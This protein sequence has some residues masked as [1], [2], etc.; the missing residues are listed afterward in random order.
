MSFKN[1]DE[2]PQSSR[3]SYVAFCSFFHENTLTSADDSESNGCSVM[4]RLICEMVS[5]RTRQ[6][7]SSSCGAENDVE[8]TKSSSL[9]IP[10]VSEF[11]WRSKQVQE[12]K[13][14]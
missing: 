1:L 11:S 4:F 7:S 5:L 13:I 12:I 10:G 2:R 9:S 14:K 8:S 3:G 6:G